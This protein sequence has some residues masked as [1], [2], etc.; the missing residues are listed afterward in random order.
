MNK[1]IRLMLAAA[2]VLSIFWSSCPAF[3][4]LDEMLLEKAPYASPPA[5]TGLSAPELYEV[6]PGDTLTA[7]AGKSG[8]TIETLAM[9]NGLRDSDR[10]QTG[11]VLKIPYEDAKHCVQ[12]G[13]T[14]WEIAGKHCVDISAI[15]SRNRLA[16]VNKIIPGQQIYIPSGFR[17][18]SLPAS[19]R[20]PASKL[21][22]WPLVGEITSPFGIRDG[23][24]HEGLDIAADEGAPIRAAAS[25]K[26]VFAGPRGTYGLAVI[27]DHGDGMST[28]Y[29]HCSKILVSENSHVDS[30]TIIALAGN[31][32]N[33]RGPHLHL[34]VQ[35]DGKAID[36]LPCLERGSFYG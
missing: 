18:A 34:E 5:V 26:V 9:V 21:L 13:E 10:I 15:A 24:P 19:S 25:G 32:G 20:G 12:P 30:A 11:Q 22:T 31:T 6:R 2:L 14:L 29:A 27:I 7:I 17:V 23:R 28:L 16:D 4:R 33:S 8:F 1:N 35:K 36:P 3:A